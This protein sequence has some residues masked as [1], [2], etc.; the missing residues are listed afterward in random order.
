MD[1]VISEEEVLETLVLP[2]NRD[3]V[4]VVAVAPVST[5]ARTSLDLSTSMV[6]IKVLPTRMIPTM[7]KE[8]ELVLKE[9]ISPTPMAA[10]DSSSS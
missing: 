10:M 2:V 8:A 1:K 4:Q 9:D 7:S 6:A 3:T 5:T